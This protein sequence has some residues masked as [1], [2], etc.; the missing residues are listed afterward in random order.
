MDTDSLLD[1]LQMDDRTVCVWIGCD[2][3]EVGKV[4]RLADGSW[5]V[6]NV[7]FRASDVWDIGHTGGHPG[8]YGGQITT[9]FLR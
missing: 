4:R 2:Q 1:L 7:R 8:T 6:V 5:S 9:L 3:T